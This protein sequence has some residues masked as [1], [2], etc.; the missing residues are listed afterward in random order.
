M[1]N[2]IQK[3][4]QTSIFLAKPGIFSEKLKILMS[5]NYPG[6]QYFLLKLLTHF[7]LKNVFKKVFGIFFCLDLE[8]FAKI[9]KTC[10]L[11]TRFLHFH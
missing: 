6:V 5:P 11:H 9:K 2:L 7:L 3:F 1:Q 10:F 4:K 8:L